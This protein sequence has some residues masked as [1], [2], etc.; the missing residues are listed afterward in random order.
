MAA[1]ACEVALF[2]AFTLVVIAIVKC[3]A[4]A[5]LH[6]RYASALSS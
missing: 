4:G 5:S 6:L 1:R 2:A 3:K